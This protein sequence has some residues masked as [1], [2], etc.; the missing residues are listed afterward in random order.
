MKEAEPVAAIAVEHAA[1]AAERRHSKLFVASAVVTV[2]CASAM[3]AIGLIGIPLGLL[4]FAVAGR[5]LGRR[6]R[7]AEIV[8]ATGDHARTWSLVGHTVTGHAPDRRDLVLSLPQSGVR[9]L[10]ALP[11]ARVVPP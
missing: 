1:K 10:R 7:A 3:S 11:A 2:G 4:A 5:S 8:R 6:R 9:M